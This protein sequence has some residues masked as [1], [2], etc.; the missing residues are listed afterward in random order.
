MYKYSYLAT[1]V[2]NEYT[3]QLSNNTNSS[4]T[5]YAWSK[6]L[7]SRSEK[8]QKIYMYHVIIWKYESDKLC[9]HNGIKTFWP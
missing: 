4:Q 5:S 7:D 2:I 3:I 6:F 9:N 8:T 1:T